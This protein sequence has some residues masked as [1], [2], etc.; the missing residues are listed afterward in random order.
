M[1]D[2]LRIGRLLDFCAAYYTT[3]LVRCA[4]FSFLLLGLVILF[5]KVFF[6]K[7]AFTRG[8]LWSSFLLIPFLGKLKLFYENKAV[9][10][11]TWR[12]TAVTMS[13]I[14]ADR[15]Y[16]AGVFIAAVCIFGK[17]LRLRKSVAGMERV[18]LDNMQIRITDMNVTPFTVGLLKPMIVIPKVVWESYSH[19]ELESVVQHEQTHIRLG[20]LWFGI[21]WDILR[22]LLWVNPFL[23]VFQKQFRADMEDICDRV[24]IQGGGGMAH[25]YGL[26]LLKTLKLLRSGTEGTPPAATYVGEKEFADVKRRMEAIAGFRPYKKRLYAG[27]AATTALVIASIQ[28]AVHTHS[29]GRC[30]ESRDIMIGNYDSKPEIVSNDTTRLS[31]MISYDDR[32][33]YVEREAFEDFL[34]ENNAEGEIWIVFGGFY[35]LPGLGGATETCIYESGSEDRIVQIPYESIMDDWYMEL[36]KL[37]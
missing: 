21:A 26:M 33:V 16:M 17:R 32:Y 18:S 10:S 15:F 27:M 34:E 23:T 4:V 29:Y 28:L 7:R 3:Q 31:R 20:H 12:L 22:C 30:N 37:L 8:L 35:K 1:T 6:S 25:E 2:W 11:M 9:L 24:C 19:D 5:R 36:L 14:W 13:W